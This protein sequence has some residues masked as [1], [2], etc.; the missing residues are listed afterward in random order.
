MNIM[1][2]VVVFDAAD[3]GAESAFWAAVLD[4]RVIEDN[5]DGWHSVIDAEGR[6]GSPSSWH[7]TMFRPTGRTEPRNNRST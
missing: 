6:G 1:R 7:Q 3:L 2:Q 5:D 4:G